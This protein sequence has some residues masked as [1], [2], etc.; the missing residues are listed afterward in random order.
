MNIF[1]NVKKRNDTSIKKELEEKMYHRTQV[2]FLHCNGYNA[3]GFSNVNSGRL[4]R[5]ILTSDH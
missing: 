3:S 4:W 5:A 1:M 2:G